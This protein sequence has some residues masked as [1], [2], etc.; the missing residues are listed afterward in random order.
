M[1]RQYFWVLL[2]GMASLSAGFAIAQSPQ[3]SQ[4][5]RGPALGSPLPN[6]GNAAVDQ[7]R[8]RTSPPFVTAKREHSRIVEGKP[9][10]PWQVDGPVQRT[11]AS[12][13]MEFNQPEEPLRIWE[14]EGALRESALVPASRTRSTG[15]KI[16]NDNQMPRTLAEWEQSALSRNPA[17]QVAAAK[18]MAAQGRAYQAG[19]YPNP[20][21]GYMADEIGDDGTAGMQGAFLR[22]EFVTGG[23]LKLSRSVAMREVEAAQHRRDAVAQKVLTDVRTGFY[24]TLAAQ[25]R[26]ELNQRLADIAKKS[27][28]SIDKLVELQQAAPADLL[29]AQIESEQA[30][31]NLE[32][33]A[34]QRLAAWQALTAVA[35]NEDSQ[36]V[37]LDGD[38]DTMPQEIAWEEAINQVLEENPQIAAIRAQSQREAMA[39]V[40]AGAEVIPNIDAQ[41]S[42][43]HNTATDDTVA[44]V[45]IGVMLPIFNRNE[46]AVSEALAMSAAMRRDMDRLA[47]QLRQKLAATYRDYR[48]SLTQV[49]AYDREILPKSKRSL[50]LV[51]QGFNNQQ[52]DFTTLLTAQRTYFQAELARLDAVERHWNA[53]L[54]MQ[55]MLLDDSLGGM[56]EPAM[57]SSG[58]R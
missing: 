15:P 50:E 57:E 58:G 48:S 40:R 16:D 47:L 34:H 42:V 24:R 46:G 53:I 4:S 28:D 29:Q 11:T 30:R 22:Q 39:A 49:H 37:A 14:D 38:L 2:V 1:K 5:S 8:H 44:S 33:A 17:L 9:V 56:E 41:V 31:V 51:S 10:F 21:A 23:K 35:G 36:P 12:Q 45:E 27:S 54:R 26:H 18:V 43:Q 55:G 52:V 13:A 3:S 25:R 20:H 19:L 6:A 7:T 32:I